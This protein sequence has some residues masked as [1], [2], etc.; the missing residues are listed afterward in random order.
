ML[1]YQLFVLGGLLLVAGN[2]FLNLL[3]FRRPKAGVHPD[4]SST[5]LVSIMIP[6]R[7]EELRL[8][9]CLDSLLRQNY[10]NLEWIVMDDHSIDR[11]AELVRNR[12]AGEPRLRLA[13]SE[14]LPEGWT[15][16][17][18]ACW[19]LSRLARGEIL[20]FTDAD[21]HHREN[22]VTDAVALFQKKQGDLLSLWPRQIAKT[23]SEILIIPFVHVLILFYLPH[24]MPSFMRSRS[25]GVANGQFMMFRRKAYLAIGGHEKVR[26]HMV[27]DVALGREIKTSGLRLINANGSDHV[28]CRMYEKFPEV[29]E[30][31]TK[32]L[33]AGFEDNVAG[34][35]FLGLLQ[36]VLLVLPFVFALVPSSPPISCVILFQI[37][38]IFLLRATV[39]W[40][41]RQPWLGVLV[42][43]LGQTLALVIAFNSWVQTARG[44][45]TWKGRS[46][47]G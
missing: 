43:P 23:W 28:S 1:I 37:A 45:L 26:S 3:V 35:I 9:P 33:R 42:H 12:M 14:P 46:Y 19:Q 10:S 32:N 20:L 4:P 41:C 17:A 39:A 21:T 13:Q 5:P 38:L 25:L 47:P 40:L 24:W 16:K 30:G 34:F 31:F 29:W 6:A 15:G 22:C 11:T 36:L 18:W 8:G 7:N 44:K 2:L 27:E